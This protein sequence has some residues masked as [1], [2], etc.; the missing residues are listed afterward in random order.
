MVTNINVNAEL[1]IALKKI[2]KI[3]LTLKISMENKNK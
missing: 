2:T 1:T 3:S